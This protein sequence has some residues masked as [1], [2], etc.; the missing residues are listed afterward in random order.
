MYL[1]VFLSVSL[2]LSDSEEMCSVFLKSA[3][4][5]KRQTSHSRSVGRSVGQSVGRSVGRWLVTYFVANN[6]LPS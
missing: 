3:S 2:T 4:V 5:Q 1:F 6:N